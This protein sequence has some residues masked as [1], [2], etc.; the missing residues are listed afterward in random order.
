LIAT[1]HNN[2]DAHSM[3]LISFALA[4]WSIPLRRVKSC[5]RALDEG[6]RKSPRNSHADKSLHWGGLVQF[7][8][9]GRIEIDS[10]TVER[11]I[12]PLVL[13]RNYAQVRIMRSCRC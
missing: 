6:R 2:G 4:P 13:T 9:D 7:L 8:D 12:R 1:P 11:S 5:R 3:P 10:N